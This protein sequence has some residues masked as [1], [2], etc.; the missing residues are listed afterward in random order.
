MFY[1]KK[2]IFFRFN[3]HLYCHSQRLNRHI[4]QSDQRLPHRFP[5]R[6]VRTQNGHFSAFQLL[7]HQKKLIYDQHNFFRKIYIVFRHIKFEIS[8]REQ[9]KGE[10]NLPAIVLLRVNYLSDLKF[11][12]SVKVQ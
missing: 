4:L 3:L 2:K 7:N 8:F 5:C 1:Q 10:L 11:K 6:N 9:I 12:I